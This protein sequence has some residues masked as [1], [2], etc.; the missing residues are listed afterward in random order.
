MKF[1][2]NTA[3]NGFLQVWMDGTQIVDHKGLLGYITPGNKDFF[4]FGYYNWSGSNFAST[5]KVLLRS[6]VIVSDP[7]GTKYKPEDL[8][9]YVN[10]H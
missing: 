3:G 2:L 1:K 6:P 8:R 5:R 4:K 9:A 7:S 10:A